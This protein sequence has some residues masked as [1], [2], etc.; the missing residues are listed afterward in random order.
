MRTDRIPR[1]TI[2]TS[3]GSVLASFP[4]SGEFP[5]PARDMAIQEGKTMLEDDPELGQLD[6]YSY[7][8][9][10]FGY[11]VGIVM[12]LPD[13]NWE[14]E[15]RFVAAGEKVSLPGPIP[16]RMSDDDFE[17]YVSDAYGDDFAK[18]EGMRQMREAGW[19]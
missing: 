6:I 16:T 5:L 3:S 7:G 15:V 11:H 18:A 2:E 17:A 14:A 4:E 8:S 12:F 9:D 13:R 19:C 1:Y 10:D